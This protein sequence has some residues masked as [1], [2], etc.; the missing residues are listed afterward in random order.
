MRTREISNFGPREE[1]FVEILTQIGLSKNVSKVFVYLALTKEATSREIELGADL[2]QPEVSVA[3]RTLVGNKWVEN[4]ETRREGKG[5]P[6]RIYRL[7][8][9]AP[10]IIDKIE[11]EKREDVETQISLIERLRHISTTP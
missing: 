2:R 7:T 11:R 5:R 4:R 3:M 10:E 1:E 9:P 8:R 6:V